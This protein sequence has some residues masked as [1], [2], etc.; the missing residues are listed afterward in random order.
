VAACPAA[1]P[2]D[3]ASAE[4]ARDA[5]LPRMSIQMPAA[6]VYR[7][8]NALRGASRDAEEICVRLREAPQVGGGLQA[9]VETFLESHRTAGRAFASEL[10]WLGDTV[11]SVA[12]SWLHLDGSLVVPRGRMRAE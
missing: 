9:A 2:V 5:T 11:A 3:D 1:V 12:D 7:L 10:A 4:G 8:A 6:E